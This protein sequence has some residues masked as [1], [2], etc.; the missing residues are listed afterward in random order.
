ME[1]EVTAMKHEKW[2]SCLI[3]MVLAFL[4]SFGGMG[5][6]ASAFD[7]PMGMAALALGCGLAALAGSLCY[8]LKRGDAIVACVFALVL[9]YL[10][11]RG[12]LVTSFETLAYMISARYDGGYGWGLVGKLSGTVTAAMLIAGCVIALEVARMV[13]R[14]DGFF[15]AITVAVVPLLL[16]VVV[17]DTVPGAGY[18]FLLLMGVILLLLT[19]SLRRSD[20]S[21]AN[22]LTAMAVLPL[23]AA[24]GLLFW[25]VP[26]NSYVNQMENIQDALV[27]WAAGVPELWENLTADEDVIAAHDDRLQRVDLDSLGPRREYTYAVMDVYAET[28]GTLYLREQ[29]YNQYTGTGWAIAGKRNETFRRSDEVTWACVGKVSIVTKRARDVFYYPYYPGE[30]LT[31]TGGSVANDQGLTAYETERY[32]LPANW[33]QSLADGGRA[34]SSQ[35]AIYTELP[36]DTRDWAEDL[37]DTIL[38]GQETA[39]EKADAIGSYVRSSARYDLNTERMDGDAEDFARWF[40]EESDTGYCVHFATAAAV[41]L[42]AAGVDARYVTGYLAYASGG[43]TVTVTAAEAHAW[44]EYYEPRLDAW[45]V[46]EPTP[47]D[48]TGGGDPGETEETEQD[49]SG[50]TQPLPQTDPTETVPGQ[51]TQPTEATG[52]SGDGGTEDPERPTGQD[53]RP[54][55]KWLLLLLIPLGI[56]LQRELRIR[57]RRR[58]TRRGGNN[59]RCLALWQE[60]ERYGKALRQ[61]PPAELE[62]LAQKA[63]YSQYTLTAQE[64]MAFDTWLRDARRQLGGLPW[65]LRLIYKLVFAV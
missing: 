51:D 23:A 41:L 59:R 28:G 9:G 6:L 2:I 38:T 52:A 60:A 19:G 56:W 39:T 43:E 61:K 8:L 15:P 5:C 12:T 13:C 65:Y 48:L 34:G 35:P 22:T 63:K 30:A 21:Q 47:G 37:V 17:T 44:V 10:W 42:R 36:P 29:A 58:R 11:R 26:K 16:C 49:P 54:L 18:L 24:L 27:Q 55:G 33:K 46:L 14:R 20:A 25:L 7:L 57:L 32:V 53:R 50:E 40:L 45:I 62:A 3:G 4:V 31:L 64:L 1:S